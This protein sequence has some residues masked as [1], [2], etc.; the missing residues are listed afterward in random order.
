MFKTFWNVVTFKSYRDRKELTKRRANYETIKSK[1]VERHHA[2]FNGLTVDFGSFD[3]KDIGCFRPPMYRV[4]KN[5]DM[6]WVIFWDPKKMSEEIGDGKTETVLQPGP[7][8]DD[9][10]M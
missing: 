5:Q 10:Q 8:N 4:A 9:E 2:G 3:K 1:I 7:A 6:Q